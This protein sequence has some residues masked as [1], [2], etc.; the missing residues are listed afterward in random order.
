MQ[1]LTEKKQKGITM[2]KPK[3]PSGRLICES[4]RHARE[5][6]CEDCDVKRKRKTRRLRKFIRHYADKMLRYACNK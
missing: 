3:W 6:P 2:E 1:P 4:G 5:C